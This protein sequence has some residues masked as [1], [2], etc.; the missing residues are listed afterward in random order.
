MIEATI[1]KAYSILNSS[2]SMKGIDS[3]VLVYQFLMD[4]IKYNH[5]FESESFAHQHIRLLPVFEYIEKNYHR[6]ISLEELASVLN[7]TPQYFCYLF[8]SIMYIRPV[9]FINTYRINKSKELLIKY[10]DTQIS[11]IGYEVG[12]ENP[13]YFDSCFKKQ[14]GIN[15]NQFRLL[16]IG[17]EAPPS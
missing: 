16:H 2:N 10:P 11:E 15:P 7:V 4:L 9:E 17:E 8:K 6:T 5:N 13:S 3:S 12:F 1:K 14:E